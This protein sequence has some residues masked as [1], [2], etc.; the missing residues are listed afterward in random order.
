MLCIIFNSNQS[1]NCYQL[2]RILSEIINYFSL[3]FYSF[4]TINHLKLLI[5][6]TIYDIIEPFLISKLIIELKDLIAS[7]TLLSINKNKALSFFNQHQNTFQSNDFYQILIDSLS[8]S[9]YSLEIKQYYVLLYL[10]QASKCDTSFVNSINFLLDWVKNEKEKMSIIDQQ[11][12]NELRRMNM[13]DELDKYQKE[14]MSLN[15]SPNIEIIDEMKEI[16]LK[17]KCKY[18]FHNKDYCLDL[19]NNTI[20]NFALALNSI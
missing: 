14:I 17:E 18:L 5:I 10:K 16:C 4:Q 20:E 8:F 13:H 11:I 7:T 3:S 6:T 9:A 2:K 12:E 19:S 15:W 1:Y